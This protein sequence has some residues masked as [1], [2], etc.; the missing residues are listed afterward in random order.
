MTKA[1]TKITLTNFNPKRLFAAIDADKSTQELYLG[2][3]IGNA[4][5]VKN[6]LA[7]DGVTP[8]FGAKGMF[9]ATYT[10]MEK[11]GEKDD[12]GADIMRQREDEQS[13]V[14]FLPEAYM[15]PM[16]DL[17]EDEVNEDGE[18]TREKVKSIDVAYDV[19]VIKAENP[20]GYSWSLRPL[21]APSAADPL[22]AIRLRLPQFNMTGSLP[23]PATQA[24]IA[25]GSKKTKAA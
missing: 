25:D 2:R 23:A 6:A 16:L 4:N 21:F 18:V 24:A 19:F 5:G 15:G 8:M 13:G 7:Q 9:A 14:L 20:A 11:T 3:L 22:E 1:L 12:K 17:F 10:G